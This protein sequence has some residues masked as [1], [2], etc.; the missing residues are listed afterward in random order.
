MLSSC[1]KK[2]ASWKG[3]QLSNRKTVYDP[4]VLSDELVADMSSRAARSAIFEANRRTTIVEIDG[5]RFQ[6]YKSPQ[7]GEIVNAHLITD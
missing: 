4:S 2:F 6:V 5:Y 7:T 3:I 1:S